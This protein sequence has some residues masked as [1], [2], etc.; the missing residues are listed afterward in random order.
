MESILKVIY[1]F[2]NTNVQLKVIETFQ[3]WNNQ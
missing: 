1:D 2:W 3:V